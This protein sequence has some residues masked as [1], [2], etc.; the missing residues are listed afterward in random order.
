MRHTS[1]TC[2][3]RAGLT[4]S[5]IVFAASFVLG[6]LRM[7]VLVPRPGDAAI[8][9]LFELP[10]ILAVSWIA[11]RWITGSF[12]TRASEAMTGSIGSSSRQGTGDTWSRVVQRGSGWV[13]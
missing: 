7:L 1:V 12:S 11:F 6:T 3:A 9:V 10:I 2:A 5:A 13:S 8:A 4:Y